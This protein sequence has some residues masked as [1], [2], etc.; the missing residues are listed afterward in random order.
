MKKPIWP[1]TLLERVDR[2]ALRI[3]NFLYGRKRVTV[4]DGVILCSRRKHIRID[5]VATWQVLTF[6]PFDV[7]SVTYNDGSEDRLNDYDGSLIKCLLDT[8]PT[9]EIPQREL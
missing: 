2:L 3:E 1:F 7:I 8:L 5:N 4:R 9:R 6:N